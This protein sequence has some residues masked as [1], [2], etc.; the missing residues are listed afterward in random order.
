MGMMWW[1][2]IFSEVSDL[3]RKLKRGLTKRADRKRFAPGLHVPKSKP[4][5]MDRGDDD[6]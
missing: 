3:G 5:G 6:E 1:Y 4:L 2:P